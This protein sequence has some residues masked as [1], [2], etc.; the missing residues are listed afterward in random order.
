MFRVARGRLEIRGNIGGIA[1]H[2]HRVR[3]Y[4]MHITYVGTEIA[5]IMMEKG[6]KTLEEFVVKY[7]D[8][9]ENR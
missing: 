3:Y 2:A 9:S 8:H 1:V 6:I 5:G 4:V 7:I